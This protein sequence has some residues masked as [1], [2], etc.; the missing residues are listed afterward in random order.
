MNLRIRGIYPLYP[1]SSIGFATVEFLYYSI[2]F[3]DGGIRQKT[4]FRVR[5]DFYLA[6]DLN[7]NQGTL[8]TYVAV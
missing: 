8:Y 7:T 6:F 5:T 4:D 1:Y 2:G 3:C